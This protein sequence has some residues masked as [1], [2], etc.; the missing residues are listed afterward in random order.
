MEG[1]DEYEDNDG[2][3]REEAP[4]DQTPAFDN[5]CDWIAVPS[6][7]RA[8]FV[9]LLQRYSRQMNRSNMAWKSNPSLFRCSL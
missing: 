6:V 5:L 3:I 9:Q 1:N 7:D 8:V 2:T 4:N